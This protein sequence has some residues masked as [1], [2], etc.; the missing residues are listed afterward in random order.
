MQIGH[1]AN[2]KQRSSYKNSA[3]VASVRNLNQNHLAKNIAELR[4]RPDAVAR[5]DGSRKILP[6]EAHRSRDGSL[7]I[8]VL[9]DN[10]WQ[11]WSTLRCSFIVLFKLHD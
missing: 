7:K 3:H 2:S 10:A 8:T 9:L 11:V 6:P 1:T 4:S 5:I